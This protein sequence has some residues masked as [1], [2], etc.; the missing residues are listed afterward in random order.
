MLFEQRRRTNFKQPRR[1]RVWLVEG[2]CERVS[3]QERR[4]NVRDSVISLPVKPQVE[5]RERRLGFDV[6]LAFG[7]RV[8]CAKRVG[9]GE[10]FGLMR[11]PNRASWN[12]QFHRIEA[13]T[14]N[15]NRKSAPRNSGY[16]RPML[17]TRHRVRARRQ[18]NWRRHLTR[19]KRVSRCR[20]ARGRSISSLR[21]ARRRKSRRLK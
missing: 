12:G 19:Q 5:R 14:G 21:R 16:I 13:K 17:S 3:S 6:R 10:L 8:S 11:N 4:Q 2:Q 15:R 18:T 1:L 20:N 9:I 7:A